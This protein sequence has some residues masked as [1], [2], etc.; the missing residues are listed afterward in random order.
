MKLNLR[1]STN[2][3][4]T[5]LK[6][7]VAALLVMIIGSIITSPRATARRRRSRRSAWARSA[8]SARSHHDP[9]ATPSIITG[10][11]AVIAFKSGI[12]NVGIEGQMYFGAFV[13]AVVGYQLLMPRGVHIVVCLLVAGSAA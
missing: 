12:W 6:Y 2:G 4:L 7:L 11:S 5:V 10:I 3:K 13:S 9:M 8:A 1:L